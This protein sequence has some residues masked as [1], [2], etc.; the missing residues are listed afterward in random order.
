MKIIYSVAVILCCLLET[1]YASSLYKHNQGTISFKFN[2][3]LLSDSQNDGKV[4]FDEIMKKLVQENGFGRDLTL[5]EKAGPY[6]RPHFLI[7]K[8]EKRTI[9][10]I[11]D[12][13]WKHWN[14]QTNAYLIVTFYNIEGGATTYHLF[15]EPDSEGGMHIS[16]KVLSFDGRFDKDIRVRDETIAYK[17]EKREV[18]K[19]KEYV[20]ELK[21]KNDKVILYF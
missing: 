21:D 18:N 3:T 8:E 10:E 16:Y 20:I 5:Y 11:R 2:P 19:R 15:I 7:S 13:I 14:N 9:H 6:D 4:N 12:F 1:T 17:V